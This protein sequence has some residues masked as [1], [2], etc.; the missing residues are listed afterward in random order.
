MGTIEECSDMKARKGK[1]I[2]AGATVH[3]TM[4]TVV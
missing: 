4:P 2:A 3:F 1:G